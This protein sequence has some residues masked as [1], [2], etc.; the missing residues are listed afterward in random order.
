MLGIK[1]ILLLSI[2]N[3]NINY[4]FH[5][6]THSTVWSISQSKAKK[7]K[8]LLQFCDWPNISI[9]LVFSYKKTKLAYGLYQQ[10]T[11]K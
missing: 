3:A 1:K 11:G 8:A 2:L 5:S 10:S 9:C 7:R 6:F 4:T